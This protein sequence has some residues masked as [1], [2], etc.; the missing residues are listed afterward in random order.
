[1]LIKIIYKLVLPLVNEKRE[2]Y[3]QLHAAVRWQPAY[4]YML[5]Q[6]REVVPMCATHRYLYANI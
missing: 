6:H 4:T 3:I 5:T 1:M 2:T